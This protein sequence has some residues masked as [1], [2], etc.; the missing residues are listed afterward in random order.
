MAAPVMSDNAEASVHEKKHLRIPVVAAQR[1]SVMKD[2]WLT[3]TPVFVKDLNAILCRDR[4]H[5]FAP[6]L[7]Y[8]R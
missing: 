5:R 6:C 4:T 1:P 2:D 3:G 8:I 7:G